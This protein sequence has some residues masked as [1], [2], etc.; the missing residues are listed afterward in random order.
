[1]SQKRHFSALRMFA[2]AVTLEG[3]EAHVTI[4]RDTREL[5]GEEL[6]RRQC[7][8][9]LM[10]CYALGTEVLIREWE[11]AGAGHKALEALTR[12]MVDGMT[13]VQGKED[14]RAF[15][16]AAAGLCRECSGL[17]GKKSGKFRIYAAIFDEL[18]GDGGKP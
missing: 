3:Q 4:S 13:A 1:M 16:R 18:G 14:E 11:G 12:L 9:N 7:A 15:Y 8:R 17:G 6:W 5:E 10:D 2:G